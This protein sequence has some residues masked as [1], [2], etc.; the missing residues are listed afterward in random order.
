MADFGAIAVSLTAGAYALE[1]RHRAF[2]ALFAVGCG[3]SSVYRFAIGSL[4]FGIAEALWAVIAL[5]RVRG[6]GAYP[7]ALRR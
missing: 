7:P 1:R 6:K 5:N 2:A 3:L 4:P